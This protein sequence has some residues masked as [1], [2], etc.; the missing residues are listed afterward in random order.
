MNSCCMLH[1]WSHV[2]LGLNLVPATPSVAFLLFLIYWCWLAFYHS[3]CRDDYI[4]LYVHQAPT[5]SCY[6]CS[7]FCCYYLLILPI[8]WK[9]FLKFPK[10]LYFS[11]YLIPP[12]SW[13]AS[14]HGLGEALGD[15]IKGD[16]P[17]IGSIWWLPCVGLMRWK[18][19]IYVSEPLANGQGWDTESPPVN[20]GYQLA[21]N[22]A[23]SQVWRP[24]WW[25]ET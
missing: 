11:W 25:Q 13:L 9:G 4:D 17:D 12:G 23:L 18:Q 24:Y 10:N 8:T 1:G 22:E 3:D 19:S 6:D 15:D 2:A 21:S 7:N 16:F 5:K 20:T 14:A